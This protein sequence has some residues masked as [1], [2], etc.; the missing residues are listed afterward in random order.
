MQNNMS[1]HKARRGGIYP[2]DD[3]QSRPRVLLSLVVHALT[4]ARVHG[5]GNVSDHEVRPRVAGATDLTASK[6]DLVFYRLRRCIA[7]GKGTCR[8]KGR[9]NRFVEVVESTTG[10]QF[11]S[12]RVSRAAVPDFFSK[13][14]TSSSDRMRPRSTEQTEP[15][16]TRRSWV[17]P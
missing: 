6:F 11:R 17:R 13:L 9:W 2:V 7:R 14:G 8:V 5:T 3:R 10:S 15:V 1:R 16:S 4:E 12:S